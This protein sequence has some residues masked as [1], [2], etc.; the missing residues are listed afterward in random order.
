VIVTTTHQNASPNVFNAGFWDI[1]IRANRYAPS[2][3]N[4]KMSDAD[5]YL[6]QLEQLNLKG[7]E[8]REDLKRAYKLT[9][10]SSP[11]ILEKRY[12]SHMDIDVKNQ[13]IYDRCEPEI[14]GTARALMEEGISSENVKKINGTTYHVSGFDRFNLALKGALLYEKIGKGRKAIPKLLRAA[15]VNKKSLG[16][17]SYERIKEFIERNAGE[18]QQSEGGLEGKTMIFAGSIIG[19]IA[20]SI[21]SLTATGNAISNLTGTTSGLLGVFLFIVGILGVVFNLKKK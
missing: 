8:K 21:F 5:K 11:P 3:H 13:Q 18:R 9:K 14:R 6:E 15:Q 19:G 4:K 20:L 16:L 12:H 17:E 7:K 2:K 10:I 1:S